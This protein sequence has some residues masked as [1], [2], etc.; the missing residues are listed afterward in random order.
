M[1]ASWRRTIRTSVA[2]PQIPGPRLA[3]REALARRRVTRIVVAHRLSTIQDADRI[4]V[5][6]E[7]RVAQEGSF[8]EL[9][10]Q[11]G[12]F[13]RLVQRQTA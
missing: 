11:E 2:R 3:S 4:Y 7:G 13:Q 12:L 1:A 6:E 5:L 9:G 10:E 8:G